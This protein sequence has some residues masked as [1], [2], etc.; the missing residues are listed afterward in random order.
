MPQAHAKSKQTTTLTHSLTHSLTPPTH[1]PSHQKLQCRKG[2]PRRSHTLERESEV[3]PS[4]FLADSMACSKEK[5]SEPGELSLAR[6][7]TAYLGQK[8]GRPS[9][10]ETL[11]HLLPKF[12]QGKFDN[13]N[14]CLGLIDVESRSEW[15]L[16]YVQ[17]ICDALAHSVV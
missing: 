1:H 5:Q 11:T 3:S 13:L 15:S 16:M 17:G 8:V 6:P 2:R 10:F 7:L 4:N 14:V 9:I 12:Y